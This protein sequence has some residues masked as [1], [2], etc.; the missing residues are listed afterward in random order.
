MLQ[1]GWMAKLNIEVRDWAVDY[2]EYRR[3]EIEA[4]RLPI[5]VRRPIKDRTTDQTDITADEAERR[6]VA[7]CTE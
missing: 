1:R 7:A 6:S 5:I 4:G 2:A 3:K